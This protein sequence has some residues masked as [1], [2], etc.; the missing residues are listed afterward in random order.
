MYQMVLFAV[1]YGIMIFIWSFVYLNKSRDQVNQAFLWFLSVILL[2]MVLSVSNDYSDHTPFG[3]IIKTVYWLSMMSMSVFFLFFI[4]RLINRPLDWLFWLMVTVNTLTIVSRYFFPIDYA[5]P[6]FWR[7][8][9]PVV[10]PVMSTVFSLPAIVALYL[11]V[12]QYLLAKDPRQ[13]MQLR[14]FFLGIFLAL[15]MSVISE[16]LLPTVFKVNTKL[17][18]MHV[19]ILIF[20]IFTFA[21]IMKYRFLN[22]QNDYIFRKLFLNSSD[23]IIIVS[24]SQRIISINN[25]AREVLRDEALD[26]GD[27][28][29]D[30]IADYNYATNYKQQE[31][32]VPIR[33]ED[34]YLSVTQYPIDTASP[35]AIKL[36]MITDITKNKL[37]QQREKEK[38]I[39]QSSVDPMTE[40]YNKQYFIDRYYN[41]QYGL[42]GVPLS[43]L[44]IDVDHFKTINDQYGHMAG[45]SVLK[46]LAQSMRGVLRQNT[47][48]IRFGGDE[49]IVIL[50]DTSAEDAF[51]VAERIRLSAHDINLSAIAP[52]FMLTVS[53]GLIE[54]NRPVREMLMKADLAMYRS[55]SHGRDKTTVF[56]DEESDDVFRMKV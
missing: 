6:T 14:Y 56:H 10:A 16:Y 9:I 55:K 50:E 30:Y 34:V 53:I 12:R 43:M 24:R 51:V 49:F 52:G 15:A 13:R 27:K 42:G 1:I 32:C 25:M 45:D 40:L 46:A 7:L 2:W 39:E 3:L 18:L 44:F 20:V 33:G 19:A 29:T 8:D 54:G 41:T 37:T 48:V 35:D 17:Y 36:L 31:I 47:D 23:G 26:S 4:Y 22:I 21:S 11:V 28:L 5:D 38:L